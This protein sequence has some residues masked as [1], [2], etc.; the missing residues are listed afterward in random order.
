MSP[1]SIRFPPFFISPEGYTGW[2]GYRQNSNL[3]SYRD[4][5]EV[6]NICSQVEGLLHHLSEQ[7]FEFHSSQLAYMCGVKRECLYLDKS[8]LDWIQQQL[9]LLHLHEVNSTLTPTT[10]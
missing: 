6:R 1:N 7:D 10:S 2:S 3:P 8:F 5:K 4:G 9:L